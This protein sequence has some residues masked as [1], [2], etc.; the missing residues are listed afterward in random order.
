MRLDHIA[1]RVKD[2]NKAAKF[3]CE[4][5]FYK[6]DSDIPDGFDI[7]FEDGTNAK[8]LVLVPF[9]CSNKQLN[10]KEYFKTNV[11]RSAEYHMAPEIFVSEGSDSSIIADWVNKNGPGI[12]HIAY[13]T[14][15]VLEMMKHWKSEGV[16]FAS[17]LPLACQNLVQIFT[18]PHP[19]TGIIYELIQRKN[20]GFC[21]DNVKNLMKSTKQF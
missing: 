19:V 14:I 11:W 12:H 1:Y 10:M 2:R 8:C 15:N 18:K 7:Q 20:F 3:F 9:E 4:T 21:K 13:E 16:E 17:T 6:H 5:M